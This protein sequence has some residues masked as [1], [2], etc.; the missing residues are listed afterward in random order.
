MLLH[1]G[2][3]D[4]TP[5]LRAESRHGNWRL[6][7][8]VY[9][10]HGRSQYYAALLWPLLPIVAEALQLRRRAEDEDGSAAGQMGPPTPPEPA[11]WP[12]G[13]R[14]RVARPERRLCVRASLP[15]PRRP[16]A[17]PC[18][19]ARSARPARPPPS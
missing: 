2:L 11:R 10:L 13:L 9:E 6:L 8:D 7:G 18:P 15:D 3:F 16:L 19:P 4:L 14:P 17:P 5:I 1:S 12:L